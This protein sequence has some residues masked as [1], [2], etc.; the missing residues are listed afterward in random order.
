MD[1]GNLQMNLRLWLAPGTRSV[2]RVSGVVLDTSD[3]A[4]ETRRRVMRFAEFLPRTP[5]DVC[6]FITILGYLGSFL[7]KLQL[8]M[9]DPN[10]PFLNNRTWL[11]DTTEMCDQ[12][13]RTIK[14]VRDNLHIDG[15]R[16]FHIEWVYD[17]FVSIG[18]VG[19]IAM[20]I[21][22]V[23]SLLALLDS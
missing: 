15:M 22:V 20:T 14:T 13:S 11:N 10:V 19:L 2:S 17:D 21:S 3:V 23:N 8:A 9:N 18:P 4:A 16:L 7:D 6:E 5:E 12:C 1:F